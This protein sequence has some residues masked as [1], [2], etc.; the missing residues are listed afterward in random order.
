[1]RLAV[2]ATNAYDGS[3]TGGSPVATHALRADIPAPLAEKVIELAERMHLSTDSIVREA[4][5]DWIEREDHERRLIEAG[6]AD[7]D[8]RLVVDHED[9][10]AWAESLSTTEPLPIPRSPR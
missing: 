5:T 1:M 6:Q 10:V 7:I 9:V 3:I 2:V 8:A 4:L